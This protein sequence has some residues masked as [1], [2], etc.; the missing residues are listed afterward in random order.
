MVQ[1]YVTFKGTTKGIVDAFY[2]KQALADAG[3]VGSDLVAVQGVQ[4][5][6]D[7]LRA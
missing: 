6:S 2:P 5:V 3:A 1:A 7:E 4:T